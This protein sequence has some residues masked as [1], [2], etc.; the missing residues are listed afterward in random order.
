[1]F[2]RLG[3][4][5]GPR[6][7]VIDRAGAM[8]VDDP[9]DRLGEVGVGVDVVQLAGLDQLGDDRPAFRAAVG[10]GKERIL[11]REGDH[12]F[13]L[14]ASGMRSRFIIAGTLCTVVGSASITAR[15][16]PASG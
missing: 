16:E 8:A 7:K 13:I 2:E 11:A 10:A 6:E 4:G 14:P 12:P 1:V 5:V 3:L 9:H 15:Y